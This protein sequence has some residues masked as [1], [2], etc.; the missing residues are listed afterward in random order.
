MGNTLEL[1]DALRSQVQE[2]PI[3]LRSFMREKRDG[4]VRATGAW[5]S[6]QLPGQRV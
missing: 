2:G 4:A 3:L 5:C 1:G 6:S